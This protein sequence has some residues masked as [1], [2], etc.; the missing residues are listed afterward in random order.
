[1]GSAAGNMFSYRCARNLGLKLSEPDAEPEDLIQV[2]QEAKGSYLIDAT[3]MN[4]KAR[5]TNYEVNPLPLHN[6]RS[7]N[8]L[9][10]A[11]FR[12]HKDAFNPKGENPFVDQWHI[13]KDEWNDWPWNSYQ[14]VN[15]YPAGYRIPNQRELLIMTTRM[16]ETAWPTFRDSGWGQS[17]DIKPNYICQTAF[18]LK[19]TSPYDSSREGFLWDSNSGNFFLQNSTSDEGYVRPVQDVQ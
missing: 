12:V 4:V 15:P 19:G 13:G 5:R 3:N 14:T 10:Y 11:K 17:A 18:S 7:A 2:T 1:M 16:P 9:P 8:N 6:E